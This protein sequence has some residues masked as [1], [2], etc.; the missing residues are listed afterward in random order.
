MIKDQA[1]TCKFLGYARNHMDGTYHALNL[2]SKIV[3]PSFD[4]QCLNKTY[5][6]YVSILEHTKDVTYI[7]KDEFSL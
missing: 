4:V 2:C 1:I 7:L 3:V 6:N 5:G